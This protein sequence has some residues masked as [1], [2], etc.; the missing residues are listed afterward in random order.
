MK[1]VLGGRKKL[2]G[3]IKVGGNK[4]SVFPCVAAA[5]L[6]REEVVLENIPRIRDVDVLVDILTDIGVNVKREDNTLRIQAENLGTVLPKELMMKLRGSVVL[7]GAILTR[8]KK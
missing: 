6:T 2:N 1:Y 5:L 8:N 3:Q 7:A 4:N